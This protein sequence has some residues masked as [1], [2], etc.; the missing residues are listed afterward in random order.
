MG[1]SQSSPS[2]D[3]PAPGHVDRTRRIGEVI[4]DKYGIVR[5]LGEGGMGVVYE[6]RHRAIGRR[7]AMKFLH[8]EVASRPSMVDRFRREA[9]T[10]ANLPS[11]NVVAV[12]DFGTCEDGSPYLVMEYLEGEDLAKLLRR[13]GPLPVG[14]AIDFVTQVCRGLRVA[15]R[16]GV[17]HRDLKPENLFVHHDP[18]RG[19]IV[20]ILDFGIAK[21]IAQ[22]GGETRTQS[23]LTLGTPFYMSPEQARGDACI[24]ERTDIYALGVI[25]YELLS[26][27]KP[28]PGSNATAVLFHLLKHP[29]VRV[30][31]LRTGLPTGLGDVIHRAFAFEAAER[32]PSIDAL[33]TAL[34]PFGEKQATTHPFIPA[35][36]APPQRPIPWALRFR[37]D[38]FATLLGFAGAKQAPTRPSISAAIVP[39]RRRTARAAWPVRVTV[40]VAVAVP[41]LTRALAPS[42]PSRDRSTTAPTSLAVVDPERPHAELS[43]DTRAFQRIEATTLPI[44]DTRA[45]LRTESTVLSPSPFVG[46]SER[47]AHSANASLTSTHDAE[48]TAV[49][50]IRPHPPP[51]SLA[52]PLPSASGSASAASASRR[53]RDSLYEP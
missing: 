37:S 21:L 19:E 8:V 16:R 11:E 35:A 12:L 33:A 29:P 49:D 25:L 45:S 14:R 32:F 10:A 22:V 15:H 23:G 46:P 7:F 31:A 9:E 44:V 50:P 13:T 24:D 2:T 20:K 1:D 47:D 34:A 36:M 39:P 27:E 6:V 40:A 42:F 53:S 26:G 52:S 51:H 28:H 18:D 30:E 5:R 48:P 3:E 41:L 4:G 38:A 17:V 43:V